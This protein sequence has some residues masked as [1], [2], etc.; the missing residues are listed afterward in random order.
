VDRLR[1]GRVPTLHRSGVLKVVFKV[2]QKLHWELSVY[3]EVDGRIKDIHSHRPGGSLACE[4]C[5]SF[6]VEEMEATH[7]EVNRYFVHRTCGGRGV[8]ARHE[9]MISST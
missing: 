5:A 8:K 2:S 7:I 3:H 4:A 1:S 6:G 9:G